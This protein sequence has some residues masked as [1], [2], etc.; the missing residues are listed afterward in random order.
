MSDKRKVANLTDSEG[1]CIEKQIDRRKSAN[2]YHVLVGLPGYMP[3]SNH[4][5]ETL[6]EAGDM[7]YWV[8]E[9]FRNSGYRRFGDLADSM[10]KVVGNKH[11]GYAVCRPTLWPEQGGKWDVWQTISIS[12]CDELDCRCSCGALFYEED[13]MCEQCDKERVW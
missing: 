12:P 11:N 2:H 10:G 7:A 5:C 9:E 8:A 4:P 1:I 6:K 13:C 3:A